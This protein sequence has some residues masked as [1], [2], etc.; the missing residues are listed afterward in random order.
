MNQRILI[1]FRRITDWLNPNQIHSVSLY[2]MQVA[3]FLR[4]SEE[5]FPLLQPSGLFHGSARLFPLRALPSLHLECLIRCCTSVHN[6]S[7]LQ[8][9]LR[10]PQMRFLP[11]SESHGEPL[12]SLCVPQPLLRSLQLMQQESQSH[13]HSDVQYM[14]SGLQHLLPDC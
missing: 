3:G 7:H 9:L 11:A 1:L 4:F 12:F 2:R 14:T 13:N 8:V 5:P 6:R 10:K